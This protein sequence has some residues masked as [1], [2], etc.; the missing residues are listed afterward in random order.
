MTIPAVL[1][2]IG[3]A[4]LTTL[5][6]NFATS[7]LTAL[8]VDM[9]RGE[10]APILKYLTSSFH[11]TDLWLYPPGFVVVPYLAFVLAAF[12]AFVSRR[13]ALLVV[14]PVVAFAIVLGL[15]IGRDYY[16]NPK[17]VGYL[18]SFVLRNLTVLGGS[19]WATRRLASLAE[20]ELL[21]RSKRTG[22]RPGK[23]R[24]F[25]LI[26]VLVIVAILGVLVALL[27]P[28]FVRARKSANIT[29]DMA[30]MHGVYLAIKLYE[31]DDGEMPPNLTTLVPRYVPK[32]LLHG[33][34][35]PRP[36]RADGTYPA[37]MSCSEIRDGVGA[38]P[39]SPYMVSYAYL[40][41]MKN[42][43]P[44]GVTFA[45]LK[46]RPEVGLLTALHHAEK[47]EPGAPFPEWDP[48]LGKWF[49]SGIMLRTYMD[50]SSR[51]TY[52]KVRDSTCEC[53]WLRCF[54]W[55]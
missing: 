27:F 8:S 2:R 29:S 21:A 32:E 49:D 12:A 31:S 11:L 16:G 55:R 41:T 34:G 10:V 1:T 52:R 28:V 15:L 51:A 30:Q 42:Q 37:I 6:I 53:D 48:S 36:R 22:V 18:V 7:K 40:G 19:A 24:A 14:G 20:S 35:D 33:V 46:S 43:F 17:T 9:R 39:R 45:D 38:C 50:G 25:T 26:E 4:L 3:V 47:T 44:P 5:G 23:T 54:L 13:V